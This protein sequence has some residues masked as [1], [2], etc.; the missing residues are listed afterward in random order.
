[1]NPSRIGGIVLLVVGVVLLFMGLN[2]TESFA[3]RSSR[4]FTGHLTDRTMWFLILGLVAAIT[5]AATLV[6]GGRKALP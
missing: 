1:M 2:A 4:F 3:D 5:G 6:T